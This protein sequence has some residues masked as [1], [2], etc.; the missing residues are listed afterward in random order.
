MHGK[1]GRETGTARD[2]SHRDFPLWAACP[3]GE[4]TG[5]GFDQRLVGF[6]EDS[7]HAEEAMNR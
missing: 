4:S 5:G 1:Q 6:N 3:A 7:A 2:H